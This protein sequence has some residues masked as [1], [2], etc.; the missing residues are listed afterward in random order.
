MQQSVHAIL[1]EERS[2]RGGGGG[3]FRRGN[4]GKFC[5]F[6]YLLIFNKQ[7]QVPAA[8]YSPN[9]SFLGLGLSRWRKNSETS[10]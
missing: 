1:S 10:Y 2:G 9:P 5:Q 3:G 8:C 4:K 6:C 7:T